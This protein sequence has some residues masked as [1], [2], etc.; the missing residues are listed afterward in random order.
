MTAIPIA[1]SRTLDAI[2]RLLLALSLAC[3]AAYLITRGL[4]EFTGSVVVKVLSWR[5]SLCLPFDC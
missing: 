2:D 5:R 3:G 4:P 1:A